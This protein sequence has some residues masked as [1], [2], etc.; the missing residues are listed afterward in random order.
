MLSAPSMAHMALGCTMK[1][2]AFGVVASIA[3]DS[4][5]F[6]PLGDNTQT[7]PICVAVLSQ[8]KYFFLFYL[9]FLPQM[10][11]SLL[12]YSVFTASLFLVTCVCMSVELC[13]HVLYAS[14]TVYK[15]TLYSCWFTQLEMKSA[16]IQRKHQQRSHKRAHLASAAA[17][18][19][20]KNLNAK[21]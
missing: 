3:S 16:R 1:L 18:T 19:A 13:S 10:L 2:S 11:L 14:T 5:P 7:C 12:F 6:Y 20:T 17:A 4:Q 8:T 15:N 21:L 9:F